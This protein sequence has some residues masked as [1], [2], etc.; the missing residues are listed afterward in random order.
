MGVA[1]FGYARTHLRRQLVDAVIRGEKTSTTSL[2]DEYEREGE[3][4]PKIGDRT[5]VLDYEDRPVAVIE[6][7]EVRVLPISEIDSRFARDEGEGYETVAEWRAAHERFW[8]PYVE[9]VRTETGD[10]TWGIDDTTQVVAERFRLRE[11][12]P[13]PFDRSSS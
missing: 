7:T 10:P 12:L 11:V 9:R 2:L 8:L 1:E 13:P 5:V 3:E 6:T 4:L